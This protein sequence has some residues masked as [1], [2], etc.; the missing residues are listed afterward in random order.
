VDI[1]IGWGKMKYALCGN[2]LIHVY[3]IYAYGYGYIH[4]YIH[5]Y[6][7]KSVHMDMDMDVKYYIHGNP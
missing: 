5:G 1:S 2:Q 6:P 7:R 3:T 4:G